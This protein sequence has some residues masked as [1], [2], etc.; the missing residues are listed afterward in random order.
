MFSIQKPCPWILLSV[1]VLDTTF[2]YLKLVTRQVS[3][4]IDQLFP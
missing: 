2:L 1:W 3:M 4:E